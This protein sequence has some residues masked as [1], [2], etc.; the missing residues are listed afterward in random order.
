MKKTKTSTSRVPI[1]SKSPAFF[2]PLHHQEESNIMRALNLSLRK[3]PLNGEISDDDVDSEVKEEQEE[4]DLI[5]NEEEEEEEEEYE[6]KWS[7]NLE[8]IQVDE[9]NEPSGPSK[10]LPSRQNVKNFFELMF[11]KKI[12]NHVVTQTNL[13]AKQ[14]I[15]LKPDP[16]WKPLGVG[17]LKSWIG[18][19]IAMGLSRHNNIKMYWEPPWRLSIVADRFTRDRFLAI[20]KYLHLADNS[21]I[22]ENKTTNQP[23]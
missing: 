12:W 19:L 22:N 2:S 4:I 1:K 5:E 16:T 8:E 18:C 15:Q 9:F 20:K 6:T 3:I 7:S 23:N 11:D 13:Y 17:E 14:Q 10:N 21:K